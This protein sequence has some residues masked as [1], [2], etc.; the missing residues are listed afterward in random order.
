MELPVKVKFTNRERGE[1]FATVKERVN[2]Y[3]EERGIS[4][5]ANAPMIVKTIILLTILGGMYVVLML[6]IL[7]PAL[8]L[9]WAIGMGV[10]IALVGFNVGHDALHGSYSRFPIINKILAHT[11]SVMGVNIYVWKITHNLVHH[12]YTNIPKVDEDIEDLPFMRFSPNHKLKKFH[13]YQHI[14][15]FLLYCFGSISWVFYRDYRKFMLRNIGIYTN[16][17]HP[18]KEWF[19]LFLFKGIYYFMALALPMMLLSVPFWVVIIGF[20]VLHFSEGLTIAVVF[21]LAHVVELA[22]FPEPREDGSME[23]N[24]AIHQMKTTADFARNSRVVS[25]LLGGLNFQIE[26]H[27]FPQICHIHYRKISEIVKK[28]AAE[29]GVPYNENKSFFS[30]IRSHVRMLKKLGTQQDI[31]LAH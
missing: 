22:E 4:K 1:F 18:K 17:G 9:V 15:A 30:A 3:F 14:Y 8:M 29:Y 2:R 10:M 26:H 19:N 6:D 24:W 5:N 7:H 13:R 23:D 21:Q 20:V 31:A 16:N 25:W 28:A 11:Y 12:T 27:L